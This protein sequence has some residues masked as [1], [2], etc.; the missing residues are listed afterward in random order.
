MSRRPNSATAAW[1]SASHC[2]GTVTCHRD[3]VEVL[4]PACGYH[5]VGAGLGE[6]TG[7]SGTQ[8]A[9][10]TGHDSDG[11]VESEQVEDRLTPVR[12]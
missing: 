5:Y 7:E 3:G 11:P 8:A 6:S 12:R 2:S 10:G 9:A 4:A 1:A